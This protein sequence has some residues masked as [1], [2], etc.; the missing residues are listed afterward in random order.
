MSN[1]E[2]ER[3]VVPDQSQTR[4]K[5]A[6]LKEEENTTVHIGIFGFDLISNACLYYLLFL[7][8]RVLAC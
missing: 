8:E 6:D 5:I 2:W 1:G 4:N 3:R 7:V